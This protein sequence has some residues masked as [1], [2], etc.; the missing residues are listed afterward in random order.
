M[1]LLIV[2]AG[3][4]GSFVGGRLALAG[5]DV[6]LV[7]RSSTVDAIRSRGLRLT[8]MGKTL[9]VPTITAES[10]VA[11]AFSQARGYDLAC[12]T[13]KSYDTA[14][15]IVELA[16][17][18]S[19]PPTVLTLQ[20]GVGNE[21]RLAESLGRS[22]VISGTITTPVE[23]PEP[24]SVIVARSGSIGLAPLGDSGAVLTAAT[25]LRA[26][27][28]RVRLYGDYRSLKWSK[29]LMNILG[30]AVCAILDWEP[31]RVFSDMRLCALESA[32]LREGL[33]VVRDQGIRLARVGAY[34]VPLL[35]PL[36]SGLAPGLLQPLL[37]RFVGEA[38]GG[39][40]PSLHM[41]LSRG[42]GRSEVDVLN[43]AIVHAGSACDVRVPANSALHRVLQRLAGGEVA[44]SEYRG[45]PEHLL[46]EVGLS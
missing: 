5:H 46:R 21:E 15:A 30:N 27:G 33:A 6:T 45:Q 28:F 26:A 3:A 31:T 16:A 12:L 42:K 39:K 44:W 32:A 10:S 1:H 20:N 35:V 9:S 37:K 8:E 43:G 29:L 17:A 2:G 25:A 19:E 11:D 40:M 24:G 34:P 38:R 41:D 23:L 18:T 4:I 7:G 13:V 14:A 22:A 36:L